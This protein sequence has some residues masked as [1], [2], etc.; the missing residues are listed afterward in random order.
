[1]ESISRITCRI[2]LRAPSTQFRSTAAWLFKHKREFAL[3]PAHERP[4][5]RKSRGFSALFQ[6]TTGALSVFVDFSD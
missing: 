1:M 6:H 2:A 3:F 4:L 5:Q